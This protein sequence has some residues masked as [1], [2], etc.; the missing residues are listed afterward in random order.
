MSALYAIG[1]MTVA[2]LTRLFWRPKISGLDN[3]PKTGPAI[4]A[5]N[6]QSV[7]D[8]VMMGAITPRNVY[9]LAKNQYFEAPGLKGTMM[10]HIMYGLNQIPVDRSGGRASLMALDAALPVLRDGHV[11]GIFPEGTRSVDGRLYRGRPGVAKLA[12]DA[13]APIIPIGLLGFDKVQPVGASM[14]KLGPS[15]EVRIGEPLDLSQWQGGE[16]DSRGLREVTLKLMNAIQQL[17]GQEY[18]GRYAPKRPDQVAAA[19][20]GSA[21]SAE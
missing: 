1:K 6:H 15:V 19:T 14:P 18:V 8:S 17:T 12:L 11:L 4:L 10:R 16:I 2:P 9:F 20:A 3:I 21:D 13:P 7:I 5:S